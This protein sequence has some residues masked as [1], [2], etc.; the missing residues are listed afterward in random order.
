MLDGNSPAIA[1][2]ALAGDRDYLYVLEFGRLSM[3]GEAPK[4]L[5]ESFVGAAD[6]EG[7]W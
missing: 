6:L 5:D 3:L 2:S 4:L 7:H 1:R